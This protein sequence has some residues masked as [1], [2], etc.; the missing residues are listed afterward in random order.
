MGWSACGLL[1][2]YRICCACPFQDGINEHRRL[3][4]AACQLKKSE[5]GKKTY[6]VATNK[7]L[8]H[9]QVG[10]EL[11]FCHKADK[12]SFL[13]SRWTFA[14]FSSSLFHHHHHHFF[15]FFSPQVSNKTMYFQYIIQYDRGSII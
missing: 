7:L 5:S 3:A 13:L 14:V 8:A 4:V 1:Q 6:E 10:F 15:S 12:D 11:G 2:V 9:L